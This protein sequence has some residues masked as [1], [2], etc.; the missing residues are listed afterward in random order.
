MARDLPQMLREIALQYPDTTEG[1]SC[2][3]SAYKAGKK[4]FLFV[5]EK[6]DAWDMMVKLAD[7][8]DETALLEKT[9]PDSYSVGKHGWVTIRFPL[10]KGPTKKQLTTWVDESFR[11]LAAKKL[12]GLLDG[13]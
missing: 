11:L 2:N 7:S 5:G 9:L 12:V 6:E 10:G 13:V 3:K 8:L 4:S 1:T